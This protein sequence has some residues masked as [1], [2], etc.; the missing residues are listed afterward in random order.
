MLLSLLGGSRLQ[1]IQ[2]PS[3]PCGM[4]VPVWDCMR[5]PEP[6]RR[7]RGCAQI[8]SGPSEYPVHDYRPRSLGRVSRPGGMTMWRDW[9]YV[10]LARMSPG[11]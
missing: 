3:C 5:T 11:G 6:G 9:G 1:C 4:A 10:P 7:R 2:P 8:V